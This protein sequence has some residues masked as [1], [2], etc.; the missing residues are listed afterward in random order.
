MQDFL[1]KFFDIFM[2]LG[3]VLLLCLCIVLVG[4]LIPRVAMGERLTC[5]CPS[6]QFVHVRI[7]PSAG[8]GSIGRLHSGDVIDAV[9]VVGNFL[10]FEF[11]GGIG[12][13]K[14][15][16]FEA[17]EDAEFVVQANG[18]VKVRESAGG[19]VKG[20]V[21]PGDRLRV[22]AWV[23]SDAEHKWGRTSKGYVDS[24]FLYPV[25]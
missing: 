15:T 19:A 9:E 2:R 22:F 23:Y 8:S 7:K 5:I 17:R 6:S 21:T 20:F 3:L 13:A 16:L 11:E 1:N 12:Y 14:C 25:Q 10:R 4:V 18:R 24:R